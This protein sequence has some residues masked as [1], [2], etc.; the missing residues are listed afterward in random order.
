MATYTQKYGPGPILEQSNGVY[1]S[2]GPTLGDPS[3]FSFKFQDGACLWVAAKDNRGRPWFIMVAG[4][5]GAEIYDWA[6]F[7]KGTYGQPDAESQFAAIEAVNMRLAGLDYN[8]HRIIRSGNALV[9]DG[10][11][12]VWDRSPH[13]YSWTDSTPTLDE[14]KATQELADHIHRAE[15]DVMFPKKGGGE[16]PVTCVVNPWLRIGYIAARVGEHKGGDPVAEIVLT[17]AEIVVAIVGIWTGNVGLVVQA[18]TTIVTTW[19][20]YSQADAKAADAASGWGKAL[21]EAGQR[22]GEGPAIAPGGGVGLMLTPG[23]VKGLLDSGA[24]KRLPTA[25]DLA[26]KQQANTVGGAVVLGVIAKLLFF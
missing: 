24:I 16:S 1:A 25:H 7:A 22:V 4:V 3:K 18:I 8:P 10:K 12:Q 11:T 19:Y 6:R 9:Q 14:G 17:V 2:V 26:R 23:A 13:V 5:D 15:V 21:A 20:A